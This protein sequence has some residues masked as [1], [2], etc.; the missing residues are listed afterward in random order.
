ME[1]PNNQK[2]YD[3]FIFC[4][5][6]IFSSYTERIEDM[7]NIFFGLNKQVDDDEEW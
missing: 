6:Y 7:C 4:N 1:I 3:N 2:T 5:L